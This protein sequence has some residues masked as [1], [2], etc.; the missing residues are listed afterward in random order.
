MRNSTKKEIKEI[1][2]SIMSPEE[3]I[4]KVLVRVSRD[5]PDTPFVKEILSGLGEARAN[6]HAR[7]AKAVAQYNQD[8]EAI[9]TVL[10][11]HLK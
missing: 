5:N 10:I 9:Y 1:L 11:D 2:C 8:V 6:Q 4:K 3:I 7:I